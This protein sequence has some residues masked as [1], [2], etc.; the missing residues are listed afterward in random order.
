MKKAKW[1]IPTW[2]ITVA[3]LVVSIV[4]AANFIKANKDTIEQTK[5]SDSDEKM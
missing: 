1:Q 3:A 5:N 2:L 4:L